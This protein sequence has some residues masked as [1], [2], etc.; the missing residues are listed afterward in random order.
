VL[1]GRGQTPQSRAN[2]AARLAALRTP[3]AAAILSQGLDSQDPAVNA[4]AAHALAQANWAEAGFI[5]PLENLLGNNPAVNADAAEVLSQFAGNAE[6]AAHLL[7]V[8]ENPTLPPAARA[9]AAAA[10]GAFGT[11]DVAAALID[12]LQNPDESDEVRQAAALALAEMTGL[13][14][15]GQDSRK[16]V[17][18]WQQVRALAPAAFAEQMQRQ[19]AAQMPRVIGEMDRIER[20]ANRLLTSFYFTSQPAEQPRILDSYLTNDAP[21]IRAIG[22]QIVEIDVGGGKPLSD[23]VRQRLITLVQSDPS[24]Q[25]RAAAAGALGLDP[26][27]TGLLLERLA[28]ETDSDAQVALLGALASRQDPTAIAQAVTLLKNPSP[29]V[30]EAAADLLAAAGSALGDPKQVALRQQVETALL[31]ALDASGGN[32]AQSQTPVSDP[33]RRSIVAALAALGDV[34]L[35]DRF[36]KLAAPSEPTNVRVA[37][38]GGL[39]FLSRINTDIAGALADFVDTAGT[40]PA[41]RLKAVQELAGVKTTAYVDRLVDRLNRSPEPQADIRTA[42]WQTVMS[43]LPFMGDDRLVALAERL[44]NEDDFAR[45]VDVRRYYVQQLQT[46]KTPDAQQAA[47]SQLETIAT[48]ELDNLGAPAQAAVDFANVCAYYEAKSST[49]DDLPHNPFRAEAAALLAAGPPYE[50]AVKFAAD[51]LADP[52]RAAVIPDVLEQF[53]RVANT[54]ATADPNKR[55]SLQNAL[56]LVKAF[57]DAKLSI[58]AS[59]SYVTDNMQTAAQ[60]AQQNLANLPGAPGQ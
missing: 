17:A 10:L 60:A 56:A 3:V 24:A 37:A 1:L 28:R 32:P 31:Q 29:L 11:K 49:A 42:I 21:E 41:L 50:S 26:T 19:R 12:L 38:I 57:T 48:R 35:Y 4:V 2:A 46:R 18:W 55:D 22:A 34:N 45:E 51:T 27:V 52:K 9:P 39:G 13:N 54:L 47:A 40:P 8:A 16:W 59:L 25:V 7:T 58:P 36:M 30:A 20:G 33:L 5:A 15:L 23:T 14:A 53:P 44:K 43:W 6:V